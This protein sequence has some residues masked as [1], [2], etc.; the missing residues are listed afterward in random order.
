MTIIIIINLCLRY[1]QR[2]K[3]ARLQV[4]QVVVWTA[5][6]YWFC[7]IIVYVYFIFFL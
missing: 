1:C 4:D 7:R 3:D 2:K 5:N 6:N